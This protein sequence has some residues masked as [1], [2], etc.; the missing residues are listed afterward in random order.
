MSKHQLW[1]TKQDG[2]ANTPPT[3]D[4]FRLAPFGLAHSV[5]SR[6]SESNYCNKTAEK[7]SVFRDRASSVIIIAANRQRKGS[8][9]FVVALQGAGEHLIKGNSQQVWITGIVLS[10]RKKRCVRL[11][12]RETY[13]LIAWSAA[14]VGRSARMGEGAN[15]RSVDRQPIVRRIMT[16]SL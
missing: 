6:Q 7:A 9:R 1:R 16:V 5:K 12:G 10:V 3:P 14:P 4:L 11:A 2:R 8:K 13:F 15:F